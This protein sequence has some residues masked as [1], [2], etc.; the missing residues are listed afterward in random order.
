[1]MVVLVDFYCMR[2]GRVD[3][4][5]VCYNYRGGSKGWKERWLVEEDGGYGILGGCLAADE[6]R[7][8]RGK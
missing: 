1:M 6:K 8:D 2:K 4:E 5:E 3:V 7:V